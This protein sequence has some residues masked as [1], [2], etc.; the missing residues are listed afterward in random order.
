MYE[1]D[2][3]DEVDKIYKYQLFLAHPNQWRRGTHVLGGAKG[4][5]FPTNRKI[6]RQTENFSG[7][8]HFK[9]SPPPPS[10]TSLTIISDNI[11]NFATGLNNRGAMAPPCHGATDPNALNLQNHTRYE[12]YR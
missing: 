10:S 12:E 4:S 1:E 7:R 11:D 3:G 9:S 2:P 5:T 8:Q 6:F